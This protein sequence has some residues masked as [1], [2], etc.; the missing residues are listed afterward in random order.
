MDILRP[1]F[2]KR[3]F[4]CPHCKTPIEQK[5]Y[6]LGITD[7][8][9]LSVLTSFSKDIK[10]YYAS[11]CTHCDQYSFWFSNMMKEFNIKKNKSKNPILID[12][13][14]E[15]VKL[16]QSEKFETVLRE[17]NNKFI[18]ED[19]KKYEYNLIRFSGI[20]QKKPD[21]L[22]WLLY[23]IAGEAPIPHQDLPNNIKDI[24]NE[25]NSIQQ[26]SPRAAAALLRL[27][28]EMLIEALDKNIP[29]KHDDLYKKINYLYSEKRI[30]DEI[31]YKMM[32]SIRILGN[33]NIHPGQI[34]LSDD[35]K[36]ST[37][38]FCLIN[39]IVE[40]TITIEKMTNTIFNLIPEEKTKNL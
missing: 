26:Q 4:T 7:P 21:E 2:G 38:L 40:K 33:E 37:S 27:A 23:P 19:L 17:A 35:K 39:F 10:N 5:W 16:N 8:K 22:G 30:I 32:H 13:M 3:V 12:L 28:L 1:I 24:Y 29:S 18:G 6:G 20:L 31:I 34:I 9:N 11:Q 15:F 36:T 14:N 25:A